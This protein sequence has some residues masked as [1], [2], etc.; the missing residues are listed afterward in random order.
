MIPN[1]N[2]EFETLRKE[3]KCATIKKDRKSISGIEVE[4]RKSS[5]KE[6]KNYEYLARYC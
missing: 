2:K 5:D 6:V 4:N 3:K 1:E